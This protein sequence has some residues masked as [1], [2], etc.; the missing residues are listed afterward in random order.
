MK[1]SNQ[2]RGVVKIDRQ[3]KAQRQKR[4]YVAIWFSKN[5][6]FRGERNTDV[7]WLQCCSLGHNLWECIKLFNNMQI[8]CQLFVCQYSLLKVNKW[9]LSP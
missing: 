5:C 4:T 2:D 3:I 9:S 8:L 7:P 6:Q 1:I